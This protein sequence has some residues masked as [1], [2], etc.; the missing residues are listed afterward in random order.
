MACL[1]D[2]PDLL[3]YGYAHKLITQESYARELAVQL[4]YLDVSRQPVIVERIARLHPE[5]AAGVLANQVGEPTQFSRLGPETRIRVLAL[6]RQNEPVMPRENG[7]Y[8]LLSAENYAVW[9]HAVALL[10]EATGGPTYLQAVLSV[11]ENDRTDA[12]KAL[13]FL[14]TTEG[15]GLIRRVGLRAPFAKATGRALD[16]AARFPGN[17]TM[18]LGAREI[19]RNMTLLNP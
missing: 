12:R 11:L 16:H 18:T 9:L 6:L 17:P 4:P 19:Q 15:K 2:T 10:T 1:P 3:A 8:G 5:L 13:A 7:R 14:S